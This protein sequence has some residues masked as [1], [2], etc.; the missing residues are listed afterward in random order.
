MEDLHSGWGLGFAVISG[1]VIIAV[2]I[3]TVIK[4]RQQAN[5]AERKQ[6]KA[7]EKRASEKMNRKRDL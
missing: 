7:E 3:Y 5:A 2:I 4:V 1:I 6:Q